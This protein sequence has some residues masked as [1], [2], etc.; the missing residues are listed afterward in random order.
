MKGLAR[1]K[2]HAGKLD[3]FKRIAERCL[4]IVRTR[5]TETLQ[6]ELFFN[7][8][9]SECIVFERYRDSKAGL[10]HGEHIGEVM[11]A[12]KAI[13]EIS[14]EV[15]GNPSPELRKMLEEQG[16]KIYTPF[17]SLG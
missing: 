11:G 5:D 14:G 4:E 8:D 12:L 2:I 1:I 15:W 3:E 16:V 9:Q 17:I 10:E 13:S 6:Y 7:E